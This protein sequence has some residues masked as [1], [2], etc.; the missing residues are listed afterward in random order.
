[1]N[2]VVMAKTMRIAWAVSAAGVFCAALILT[3]P[4]AAEQAGVQ[5]RPVIEPG[6][7]SYTPAEQVSGNLVIAGSDTMQPIMV[8]LAA[9]FRSIYPGSKIGVTGGGTEKA[10]LQFLSNQSQMRR[11]D[12]FYNGTQAS[13][14]VSMLASSRP[15]TEKEIQSFRSRFGYAPTEIPIALDAMAVYVNQDNP[16]PGLTLDQLD[17][18]FSSSRKRGY[19]ENITLWGQVGLEGEWA[20]DPIH[21]YGRGK[22][23]GSR[24]LFKQEVMLDGEFK[25]E[26]Q[27]EQ[28]NASMILAVARDPLAIGFAGIGFQSSMVRTVP[29]AEKAG[30]PFVAPSAETAANGTYPL[31]RPLYLYANIDPAEAP[32]REEL[33]FLKF[34]N[35][36][37]GQDLIIRAGGY[38]LPASMVAKNLQTLTDG[39]MAAV[40]AERATRAN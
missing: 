5:D 18:M 10:L 4:A 34:I 17:A 16:V 20:R 15:L 36:R 31:R 2:S 9:G 25:P 21:L 32:D 27:H 26:V 6:I 14:H 7:P 23:S 13:G 11:G 19:P 8:K 38:P 30:M 29:L 39:A 3:G 24:V 12:G 33:E 35:S 1:M 40:P 22:Q 28:G 37:E